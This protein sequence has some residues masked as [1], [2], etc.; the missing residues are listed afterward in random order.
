MSKDGFSPS[1]TNTKDS[2]NLRIRADTLRLIDDAAAALGKTRTEFIIESVRKQAIDVLLDQRLLVLHSKRYVVF[3]DALDKPSSP[4][5][6]LKSL[7]RRTPRMAKVDER[8]LLRRQVRLKE[9]A[10]GK[11]RHC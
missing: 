1:G 6:A 5:P 8:N 2:I 11:G 7:L 4:G 3:P 10:I 9:Q